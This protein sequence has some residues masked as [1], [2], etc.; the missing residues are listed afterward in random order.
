[1]IKFRLINFLLLFLILVSFNTLL[2]K[3]KMHPKFKGVDPK[4]QT[5]TDEWMDLA[6]AY[7]LNFNHEVTIGFGDINRPNVVAQ[8]EYGWNFRE[9][10]IDSTYWNNMDPVD[11]N[12]AVWHELGHCYCNEGHQFGKDHKKYND[13]GINPPD[14]FFDDSCPKSFMYP[15]VIYQGCIYKH[16]SQYL[17]DM[18]QNCKPY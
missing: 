2:S 5:Y 4:V 15:Y 8:C 9:I 3:V 11:R 6:G 10:T 17:D 1:M 16:F 12:M 14:G 7:G 13:D 18:F